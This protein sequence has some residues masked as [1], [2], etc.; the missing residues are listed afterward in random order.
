MAD[1]P[2]GSRKN[3]IP[4]SL[5]DKPTYAQK[6]VCIDCAETHKLGQHVRLA[7]E[8]AA[9][10]VYC[11]S[12]HR[13]TLRMEGGVYWH[14]LG[15]V[16]VLTGKKCEK[17]VHLLTAQAAYHD[18]RFLGS[19]KKF[20]N[21]DP[22]FSTNDAYAAISLTAA[23]AAAVDQALNAIPYAIDEAHLQGQRAGTHFLTKMAQGTISIDQVNRVH[24]RD[25]QGSKL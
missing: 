8:A 21:G 7:R 25:E 20:P 19:V 6:G 3:P 16:E 22:D 2:K 24:E 12:Q 11:F 9:E 5:C 4:C 17:H 15:F 23:Q 18:N 10:Q 1:W 13:V 14:L